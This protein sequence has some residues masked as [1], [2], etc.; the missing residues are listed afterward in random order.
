MQKNQ[1]KLKIMTLFGTR[2]EIIRL[3]RVFTKLDQYLSH[4]MVHTGQSYDYE[5][6][7]VFFKELK[8][9]KPDYFLEVKSSSL[10]QQIAKIISRSE[11]VFKKEKPDA[12][13]VL[14]DTNSSLGAIIAKRIKIPIF[15]ME[16]GN[17]CFDEK[18][19][20]EINR[21]IIDHIADINLPYSENARLYLMR[22]GIHPG[23]IYVTGSPM[24]EVLSYYKSQINRSQI[25]KKL[26]IQKQKY[27]LVSL[28]REEN[29]DSKKS[30][31]ILI[32]TLNALAQ[33]YSLPI[34]MSTHPRIRQRLNHY[35]FKTNK[36]INFH[37][38]FGYFDYN[39]LQKN[40]LCVLSDS[41]TIL[42][43]SSILEFSA[44]QVRTNSERPEGFDQGVLILSGLNQN[45]ILQATDI[46]IKQAQAREK[47][48]IPKDYQDTNVSS[49]VL[50]LILG[51]TKIIQARR[52]L[53]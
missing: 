18:T 28:H 27:F 50:R 31:T 52:N 45:I 10:G 36:L 1:D 21:K 9:R 7:Q 22:E 30:L 32:N 53:I 14:G 37:K 39:N 19:P 48:N 16:A 8:I 26:K 20:E 46:T 11:K 23:T 17:R 12:L 6:N 3:S 4:I 47:F 41:G 43:E 25:L 29:V 49:K 51:L 40:A 15:H 5:L 13:L 38:P 34:I 33:Q 42:E 44:I 35:K 2:P 24:A